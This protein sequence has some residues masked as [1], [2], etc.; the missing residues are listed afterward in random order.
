MPVNNSEDNQSGPFLLPGLCGNIIISLLYRSIQITPEQKK[1]F[2]MKNRSFF[3]VIPIV[4]ILSILIS[5][6]ACAESQTPESMRERIFQSLSRTIDVG[7]NY[8][9]RR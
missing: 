3:R 5:G 4:L 7:I 2:S 1:V 6:F 8:L 9:R